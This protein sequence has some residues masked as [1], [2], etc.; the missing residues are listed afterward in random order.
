[1][2]NL[3]LQNVKTPKLNDIRRKTSHLSL[4]PQTLR[5]YKTFL[6]SKVVKP[7]AVLISHTMTHTLKSRT[8]YMHANL[9]NHHSFL[10]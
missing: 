6:K 3:K 4:T 2:E 5:A 8:A 10:S 1:M 7:T 9:Y